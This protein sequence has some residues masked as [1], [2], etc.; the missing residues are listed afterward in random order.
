[1][2]LK[3][4]SNRYAPGPGFIPRWVSGIMIILSIIALIESFKKDGITL[5][6]VLPKN[7]TSRMNLYV[8]W[9]GLVLFLAFVKKLGFTISSIILLSALFS[10]GTKWSQA[11]ILG[12]IVSVFA[13]V[14]FKI[15][16]QV[17]IPVNQ[18]GW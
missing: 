12:S 17:Q 14:I 7:R 1:M 4:W 18:F 16:L 13:F 10:R 2:Q 9:V 6:K 5:D 3:L 11:L 8:C 15:V